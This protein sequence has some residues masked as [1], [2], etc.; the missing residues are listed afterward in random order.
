MELKNGQLAIVLSPLVDIEIYGNVTSVSDSTV[1]I[2]IRQYGFLKPDWDILCLIIDGDTIFEFY[3]KI[4]YLRDKEII[5]TRP[6]LAG[7][8]YIEK[9]RFNRVEC[10]IGFIGRPL[11]INDVPITRLHDTSNLMQQNALSKVFKG[12]VRDIGAGGILAETDLHLPEGMVFGLNLRID[13]F[14]ECTAVIR[15]VSGKNRFGVYDNGCEFLQMS[16]EHV[17]AISLFTFKQ[18]LKKR[19]QELYEKLFKRA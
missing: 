19:R 8:N 4:E 12:T 16:L 18:Q 9:R 13:Y 11:R 3:S 1:S 6:V 2:Q 14:I 7:L 10:D 5:V 17:K 15:R